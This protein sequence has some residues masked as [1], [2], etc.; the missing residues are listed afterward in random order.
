MYITSSKA[1]YV[2]RLAIGT[3]KNSASLQGGPFQKRY[4]HA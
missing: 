4:R 1:E 2:T 3:A